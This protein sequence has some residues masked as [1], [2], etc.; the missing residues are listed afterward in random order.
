LGAHRR[1][2]RR[3]ERMVASLATYWAL[4]AVLGCPTHERERMAGRRGSRE[5]GKER[6]SSPNL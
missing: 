5:E 3:R 2:K 4:K 1:E 6:E